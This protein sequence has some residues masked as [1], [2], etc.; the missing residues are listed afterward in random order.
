MD[1][2]GG[3]Y[4]AKEKLWFLLTLC[5]G[6][7]FFILENILNVKYGLILAEVSKVLREIGLTTQV[8]TYVMAKKGI[9]RLSVT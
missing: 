4:Y 2:W 6:S 3:G 8:V 1:R 9:Q 7:H 5:I